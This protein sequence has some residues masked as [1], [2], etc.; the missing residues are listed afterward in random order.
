ML[1]I[2]ERIFW[3]KDWT[4]FQI[5]GSG[6]YF[7]TNQSSVGLEL[8]HILKATSA[9]LP[10]WYTSSECRKMDCGPVYLFG[11]PGHWL[12]VALTDCTWTG[13][14]ERQLWKQHILEQTKRLSG[15][16][17]SCCSCVIWEVAVMR[18]KMGLT[19]T[20]NM[21]VHRPSRPWK[22]KLK[23]QRGHKGRCSP[24]KVSPEA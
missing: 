10:W 15:I 2:L 13:S 11:N 18:E 12:R 6:S 14:L 5:F 8:S 22:A 7:S 24:E 4:L 17:D 21:D 16:M 9:V 23:R 3:S 1:K 19:W 20:W